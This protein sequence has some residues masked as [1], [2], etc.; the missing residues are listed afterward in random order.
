MLI[1]GP[2]LENNGVVELRAKSINIT[3]GGEFWIGS[4]SCRYEH[5]GHVT[6][7]GNHT[8]MN[9]LPI[10]GQKYLW[11]SNGATCEFHG[12]EKKVWL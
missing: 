7:Y 6:L 5:E 4:R 8:A 3:D 10:I 2:P 9:D 1:Y 11:C 12:T